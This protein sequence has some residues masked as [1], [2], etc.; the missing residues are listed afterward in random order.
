MLSVSA[1]AATYAVSGSANEVTADNSG[2]IGTSSGAYTP[3]TASASVSYAASWE[4]YAYY[5]DG[6]GVLRFGFNT[7]AVN[8]DFAYSFHKLY[9]HQVAV[10]NSTH[11]E[12]A[13]S[14]VAANL[15]T[16]KADVGHGSNPKWKLLF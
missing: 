14:Q 12:D 16:G 11:T 2:K 5:S 7:F 13:A 15:W 3:N 6:N 8:E 1:N 10:V 4:L 9:P